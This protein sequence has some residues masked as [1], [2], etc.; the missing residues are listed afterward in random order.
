M[1]TLKAML[2]QIAVDA[3]GA[4]LATLMLC[5]M[6]EVAERGFV[7]R[8]FNLLW[9]LLFVLAASCLVLVTQ[10]RMPPAENA[11]RP[12][13]FAQALLHLGLLLAAPA[14]WFL[15]PAALSVFW[16]A[17]ATAGILL[18]VL[19]AWPIFSKRD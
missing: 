7:S 13:G 3:W 14:V 11:P 2:H 4:G 5:L 16:R 19:I 8:F 9:L 18:A 17:A 10:S 1:K 15:L 6:L 12:A